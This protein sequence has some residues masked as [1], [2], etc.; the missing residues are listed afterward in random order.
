MLEDNHGLQVTVAA[1]V[2]ERTFTANVPSDNVD[3]LLDLLAETLDLKITRQG[4][5]VKI[6]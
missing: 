1:P 6:E 3:I 5:T 4:N 2:K